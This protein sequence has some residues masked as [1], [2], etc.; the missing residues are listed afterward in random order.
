MTQL[1]ITIFGDATEL[2]IGTFPKEGAYWIMEYCKEFKPYT[3]IEEVWYGEGLIPKEW[4]KGKDWDDFDNIFHEFGFT[5]SDRN[6]IQWFLD[7]NLVRRPTIKGIYING[8]RI[9]YNLSKTP[10]TYTKIDLP[11]PNKNEVFAYHG[12]VNIV[13]MDYILNIQ[14]QFFG[15]GLKFHFINC[16]EYGYILTEIEYDGKQMKRFYSGS[17]ILVKSGWHSLS[18]KNMVKS[19]SLIKTRNFL[20]VKFKKKRG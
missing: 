20:D 13:S 14:T 11:G 5:F 12:I 8:K 6:E 9:E 16:G 10:R 18:P 4:T 17:K 2:L 3:D 19:F 1:R 7:G 15:D